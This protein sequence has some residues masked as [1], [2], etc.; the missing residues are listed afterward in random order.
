[1]C[2]CLFLF[3]FCGMDLGNMKCYSLGPNGYFRR[4]TCPQNDPRAPLAVYVG[5][6]CANRGCFSSFGGKPLFMFVLC[7]FDI[8]IYSLSLRSPR[9]RQVVAIWSN[10]LQG[11]KVVF[12]LFYTCSFCMTLWSKPSQQLLTKC[13]NYY[14]D[15]VRG[16][17]IHSIL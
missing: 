14:E 2:G 8:S 16:T 13:C 7:G 1:M 5:Y 11:E 10:I 4:C 6:F 3:I 9:I 17:G 12:A 15:R